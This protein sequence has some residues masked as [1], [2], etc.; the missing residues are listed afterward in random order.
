MLP[1]LRPLVWPGAVTA[2]VAIVLAVSS[3]DSY[4][5]MR[6]LAIQSEPISHFD[7]LDFEKKQFGKLEWVGGLVLSSQDDDFGGISGFSWLSGNEFL[8]VTDRGKTIKGLLDSKASGAP[9]AI[10]QAQIGYLPD[11][12]A[13]TAKWKKD[14][15]GLDISGDVALVSFEGDHRIVPYFLKNGLPSRALSELKLNKAVYKANRGNKGMEAVVVAPSASPVAGSVVVLSEAIS[16]GNV[17]GWIVEEDRIQPFVLPQEDEFLVTDAAFTQEGDL[18]LLERDFSLLGGLFIHLRRV[19]AQDVQPGAITR[20]ETLFRGNL[21]QELD[22]MEALA[23]QPLSDGA[24]LLTM[25][26]DDNF[27]PLQRSL[28]LRFRLPPIQ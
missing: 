16:G 3:S 14:S 21:R 9:T 7:L 1:Y 8:A 23:I 19:A 20:F 18:I 26:S 12:S 5:Q 27:N 4:A 17:Q 25:V 24:S 10:S 22:N 6:S 13:R 11:L 2:L 15:E 28:L